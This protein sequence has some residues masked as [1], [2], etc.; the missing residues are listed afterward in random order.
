MLT[1]TY[2]PYIMYIPRMLYLNTNPYYLQIKTFTFVFAKTTGV[3]FFI[4]RHSNLLITMWI[5]PSVPFTST[6]LNL[7]S[8]VWTLL[9][10]S[11]TVVLHRERETG[12]RLSLIL[13]NWRLVS[14][15]LGGMLQPEATRESCVC[16]SVSQ[17][18]TNPTASVLHNHKY[19]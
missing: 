12:C 9:C 19:H 13:L 1:P 17:E 4:S 18:A 3:F 8:R 7:H 2:L 14:P 15:E 16:F 5:L 11:T 6:F 10:V